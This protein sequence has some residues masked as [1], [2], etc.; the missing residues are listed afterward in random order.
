M[1]HHLNGYHLTKLAIDDPRAYILG[2]IAKDCQSIG[3]N[4]EKCVI[5]GITR[6]NNGFYVFLKNKS[7]AK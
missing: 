7:S 5:D 2:H 3:G 1:V 6:E 4:S